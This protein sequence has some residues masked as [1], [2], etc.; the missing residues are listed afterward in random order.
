MWVLL[1]SLVLAL[2]DKREHREGVVSLVALGLRLGSVYF[3]RM[4]VPASCLARLGSFVAAL[5]SCKG[6]SE[7][8]VATFIH[9]KG[10]VCHVFT[11]NS[12]CDTYSDVYVHASI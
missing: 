1:G 9:V 12:S 4:C 8:F 2:Q 10:A 5:R 6:C 7:S 11:C 3:M